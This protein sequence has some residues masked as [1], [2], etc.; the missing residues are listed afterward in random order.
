MMS[1]AA[2]TSLCAAVDDASPS[3]KRKLEETGDPIETH[4]DYRDEL[5]RTQK[6]LIHCQKQL[7][8]LTSEKEQAKQKELVEIPKQ[9]KDTVQKQKIVSDLEEILRFF[10]GFSESEAQMC[11]EQLDRCNDGCSWADAHMSVEGYVEVCE[12]VVES[13]YEKKVSSI[14]AYLKE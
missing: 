13:E 14:I 12:D 11:R 7:I 2:T 4:I 3:K 10:S 6:A 1:E 8:D 9:V 5:L